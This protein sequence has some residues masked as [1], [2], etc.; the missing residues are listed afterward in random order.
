MI[1]YRELHTDHDWELVERLQREVWM[2]EDLAIVPS[3]MVQVIAHC[4]GHVQGAFVGSEMVA[5]TLALVARQRGEVRLWSHMSGV[6]PAYRGKGIGFRIKSLQRLWALAQGY[7]TIAWTFDPLQ[8]VNANFNLRRLGAVGVAYHVNFYGEMSDELNR[9]MPSDR[10]EVVWDLNSARVVDHADGDPQPV[11]VETRDDH[12][13][14]TTGADN[15]PVT[16]IPT[17]FTN[18]C[19]FV[20]APYDLERVRAQGAEAVAAWREAHRQAIGGALAAGYSVVDFVN[21][22][23]R[24]WHVLYRTSEQAASS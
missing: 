23:D 9:G 16:R 6:L 17:K 13:I 19:Y 2:L 1:T 22:V 18:V 7:R 10:L 14:V 15:L 8:R 5:F 12:F 3:R 20:E 21:S 4:G 11:L 24:C